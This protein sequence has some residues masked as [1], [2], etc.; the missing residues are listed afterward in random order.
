MPDCTVLETFLQHADQPDTQPLHNRFAEIAAD[1]PDGLIALYKEAIPLLEKM[2]WA[3][4]PDEP[5]LE[6]YQ[7]LFRELETHIAARGD[8][9]RHHIILFIPVAD[10]PGH[11]KTCLD[12]LLQLCRIYNYGGVA[13]NGYQKVSVMI[14]DDSKVQEN[15]QQHK[16]IAA[17]FQAQGLTTHYYGQ[18]E[19][20]QQ[21]DK[22]SADAQQRLCR[23]LGEADPAVFYH[24]GPSRMR[25]ITLLKLQHMSEG[26]GRVLFYALDSDQ[27]FRIKVGTQEGDR[28]LYALNYFYYLDEIFTG[29]NA[30]VLTGKVV[31]DPPV[32][33]A[34]MAGNFLEDVISFVEQMAGLVPQQTC[35][36]H[37]HQE[38]K[39]DDAA[40]HDMAEMFGFKRA[41]HSYHYPCPLS[42]EHDNAASFRH[43]AS[44][45]NHFFYGEHPTRKT[46]YEYTAVNASLVPA[47]TVYTG[48]YMFNRQGLKYF[49]PFAPLKLRMN[50]PVLGRII[51]A[52][53][54]ERFVSANLPMLH[55]RTFA[56]T[57]QSEYRPGINQTQQ[58]VDMADEFERQ[59]FGDVMLFSMEKLTAQSYP[60]DSLNREVITDIVNAT[61]HTIN[62]QYMAKHK[63]I[64]LKLDRLNS[65][66]NDA[67]NWW[68]KSAEF[69]NARAAFR[70]F[71]DNIEHNFGD[72]SYCYRLMNSVAEKQIRLRQ[73]IEAILN[74][75][76]DQQAWEQYVSQ[77]QATTGM[78]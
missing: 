34:V 39:S 73:I 19:Q 61:E 75:P 44:Q 26:H 27:E 67:A 58:L 57:G 76:G 74:H 62:R 68:N 69:D 52:E 51:K 53:L 18:Q 38:Q 7:A 46:Y 8:D 60:S 16:Q 56:E 21:I 13:K 41:A 5:L 23:I 35:Q 22:L 36:F 70:A 11:L 45:L 4:E 77:S 59:Y 48:N 2:L 65:V 9:E 43:F 78:V 10:R 29:T 6:L 15:I 49:I 64:I 20:L 72:D 25:N 12:S 31:G 71:A 66:M 24:K 37:Q 1:D 3:D 54:Q 28:D 47:R 63:E 30:C 42:H 14:C 32:S 55:K 17:Q 50:G 40:Y 33:P